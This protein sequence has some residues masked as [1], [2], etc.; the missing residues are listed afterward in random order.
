[1]PEWVLQILCW[2]L[3]A[4]A[5]MQEG[6]PAAL[7]GMCKVAVLRYSRSARCQGHLGNRQSHTI[8]GAEAEDSIRLGLSGDWLRLE[9]H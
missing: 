5:A 9:G 7:S 6:L 8:V 2:L 3:C 4:V 1:M